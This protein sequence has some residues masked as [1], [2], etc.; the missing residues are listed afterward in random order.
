MQIKYDK[1][2]MQNKTKILNMYYIIISVISVHFCSIQN[3]NHMP[4]QLLLHSL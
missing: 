3:L 2:Q 1:I 4:S